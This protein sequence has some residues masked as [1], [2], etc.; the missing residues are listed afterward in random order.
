MQVAPPLRRSIGWPGQ[1]TLTVRTDED[2]S[3]DYEL[4]ELAHA[5]PVTIHRSQGSE[6]PV[7]VSLLTTGS[8][9]MLQRSLLY[10]GVTWAEKL[11]VLAGSRCALLTHR[12]ALLATAAYIYLLE[13]AVTIPLKPMLRYGANG[14]NR[15]ALASVVKVLW[16]FTVPALAGTSLM[17]ITCKALPA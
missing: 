14:A 11:V 10:A 3:V 8:W 5:Y 17:L 6:Y 15:S 4:D 7:V 2:E 12:V 1:L 9:M 16:N 13:G